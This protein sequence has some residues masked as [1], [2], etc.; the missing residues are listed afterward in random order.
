MS[1]KIM[2]KVYRPGNEKESTWPPSM[3]QKNNAGVYYWDKAERKLKEGYPPP[4]ERKFGDAPAV[5]T[6]TIDP[7]YHPAAEAWTDSKSGLRHLDKATGCITTDK[8]L[9]PDSSEQ[10][11]LNSHRKKDL[12][13]ALHKSVAQIDAGTAPLTE[14]VRQLCERE[15]ERVSKALGFDAFNV[16]GKKKNARG[17][18]YRRR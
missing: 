3:P 5:I 4:T 12:H 15:N 1:E 6:D 10:R 18:K 8:K 14:E 7:Y 11:R 2:T 17:K 13:D 16:A 9:A